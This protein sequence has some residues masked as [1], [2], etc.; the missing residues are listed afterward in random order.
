[1]LTLDESEPAAV[2]EIDDHHLVWI[3]FNTLVSALEALLTPDE[4]VSTEQTSPP[5][6]REIFLIRELIRF[7]YDAE[8][9]SGT[10]DRAL[11]FP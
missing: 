5:T 4:S 3:S 8:L 9:T 6:E 7:V 10:D 11:S 1:M 2:R